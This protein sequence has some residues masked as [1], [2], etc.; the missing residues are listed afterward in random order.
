MVPVTS[1][2]QT[3]SSARAS[4]LPTA[5]RMAASSLMT[6]ADQ[7]VVPLWSIRGIQ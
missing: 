1:T 5:S 4:T 7:T 2:P 3:T 6:F